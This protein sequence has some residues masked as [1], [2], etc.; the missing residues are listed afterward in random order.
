MT[1][2]WIKLYFEILD[3]PK[4]GTL[5]DRLWRRVV[6]LFL[7]AG[8][9]HKD[10]WIPDT[11]QLAWMLRMDPGELDKEL[12]E[13]RQLGIIKG[14]P[15]GWWICN[16]KKR[17]DASTSTERS[18]AFREKKRA[19]QYYD[20][21]DETEVQRKCNE[22]ETK[23]ATD[24]IRSDTDTDSEKSQKKAFLARAETPK[25]AD[26]FPNAT[27]IMPPEG[28]GETVF[29]PLTGEG[30]KER[31]RQA[32]EQG[33]KE[34]TGQPDYGAFP[35]ELRP[36]IGG[37]CHFFE[38]TAPVPRP[39]SGKSEFARWI[40]DTYELIKVCQPVG[41]EL[42]QDIQA[43]ANAHSPPT[44][45]KSPGSL[46]GLAGTAKRKRKVQGTGPEN[47]RRYIEGEHSEVGEY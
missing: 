45:V 28:F 24:Q 29:P 23:C 21:P 13:I 16:F 31:T 3:D 37:I 6:E 7:I 17:Q 4:M 22:Q 44:I 47:Y 30:H 34:H 2:Y 25:F 32:L 27:P 35:E 26:F 12:L 15:G 40:K 1:S 43:L 41:I 9:V 19:E 14:A 8:Q 33:I 42:L 18:Q 5:S 20:N 36:W 39:R 11:K 46:I 10:G 38:L